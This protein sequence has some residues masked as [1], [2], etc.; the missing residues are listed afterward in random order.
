MNFGFLQGNPGTQGS[1]GSPGP[2]GNAGPS[3]IT[4]IGVSSGFVQVSIG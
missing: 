1:Q 2:P 3:G 4:L